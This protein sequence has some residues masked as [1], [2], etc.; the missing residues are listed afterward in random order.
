MP[1]ERDIVILTEKELIDR[2]F[3]SD[4]SP[5]EAEEIRAWLISKG[6]KI[7]FGEELRAK[8]K[9]SLRF[10]EDS[11]I[12]GEMWPLLAAR[13][14]FDT[15]YENNRTV[16]VARAAGGGR[17]MPLGRSIAIRVVAVLVPTLVVVGAWS[18]FFNKAGD[19]TDD[20]M[21]GIVVMSAPAGKKQTIILPDNS[22]VNLEEGGTLE[23]DTKTFMSDRR[24]KVSGEALF[25][26]AAITDSIGERMSFAVSTDHL[27]ITVL[28]TVFRVRGPNSLSETSIALYEGAVAVKS[29]SGDA[30][31]E[32]KRGER[33]TLN[34]E[35]GEHKVDMVPAAEMEANG[36]KPIMIFHNASLEDIVTAMEATYGVTFTTGTGVN[37][38]T[39]SYSTDFD[40]LTL[41]E[42]LDI[43]GEVACDLTFLQKDSIVTITKANYDN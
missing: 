1:Q 39:G 31:A 29:V 23:Y 20:L 2:L 8:F 37:I 7:I 32:L 3:Y 6:K 43:L 11:A 42:S 34:I 41:S 22:R 14:G 25:N 36:F 12:A 26:V 16:K 33:F 19:T 40:G 4:A 35:T 30:G 18:L 38:S 9:E 21:A 27:S 5:E 28:G 15:A 24:A 10:E 17:H 13:L